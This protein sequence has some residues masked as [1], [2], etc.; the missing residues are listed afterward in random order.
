MTWA[1]LT[2]T[3][4]EAYYQAVLAQAP[5]PQFSWTLQSSNS[6]RVVAEGSPTA[7]KLWQ[8]T[9]PNARDFRL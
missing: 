4:L 3:R 1:A 8:A 2:P 6:I 5:L 7:V 9:N